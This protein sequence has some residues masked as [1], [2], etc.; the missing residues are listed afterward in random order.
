MIIG[1]T[2]A[3]GRPQE[4]MLENIIASIGVS[5]KLRAPRAQGYSTWSLA[6]LNWPSRLI[7]TLPGALYTFFYPIISFADSTILTMYFAASSHFQSIV[8]ITILLTAVLHALPLETWA[9]KRPN[10]LPRL[11]CTATSRRS[12]HIGICICGGIFSLMLKVNDPLPECGNGN[13]FDFSNGDV[14]F[15]L[16]SSSYSKE[17][18]SPNPHDLG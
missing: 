17:I 2:L 8:F 1:K 14:P 5:M 11:G 15:G 6:Y 12:G 13:V 4:L 10:L 7:V 9:P 3:S 16:V 18:M